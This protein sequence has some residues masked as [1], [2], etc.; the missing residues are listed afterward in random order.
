MAAAKKA[1][2][3]MTKAAEDSKNTEQGAP[4]E[5]PA[6]KPAEEQVQ[7]KTEAY[8]PEEG[9]VEIPKEVD[10]TVAALQAQ[11]A[12]LTEMIENGMV[13]MKVNPV[14]EGPREP[15]TRKLDS[16]NTRTDY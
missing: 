12:K 1:S 7:V 4:V 5:S 13:G 10:P 6:E 11:V 14:D 9:A 3:T 15:V 16:G 8:V 2:A